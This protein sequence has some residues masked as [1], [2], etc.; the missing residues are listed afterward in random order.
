MDQSVAPP[1]LVLDAPPGLVL[2]SPQP[3]SAPP[4]LVLDPAPAPADS[5]LPPSI[6]GMVTGVLGQPQAGQKLRQMFD[7]GPMPADLHTPEGHAWLLR[8]GGGLLGGG[9]LPLK[10]PEVAA[11]DAM[12]S[13]PPATEVLPKPPFVPAIKDE[14]GVVVAGQ[15]GQIHSD[16]AE[17]MRPGVGALAHGSDAWQAGFVDANGQFL[18]RNQASASV[19]QPTSMEATDLNATGQPKPAMSPPDLA[20]NINLDKLNSPEEIKQVLRDTASANG[21]FMDARRGVIPLDQQEKLAQDLGMTPEDLLKRTLGQ[22]FN[23]E[24]AI[25]ARMLLDPSAADMMAKGRAAYGGSDLDKAIFQEALVRHAAIQ[26]QVS[27]MTAEAGRLLGSFRKVING[28]NAKAVKDLLD[29]FG[30]PGNVEDIAKAIAEMPP[31]KLG[32]FTANVLRPTWLDKVK[33]LAYAFWL[34]GPQTHMAN[35]VGNSLFPATMVPEDIAASLIGMGRAAGRKALN[36]PPSQRVYLTDVF[37]KQVG[38]LAGMGEGITNFA[39][40]MKAGESVSGQT[41]LDQMPN[42]GPTRMQPFGQSIPA[43]I[44]TSP[45]TLM[46]AED[47]FFKAMAVRSSIYEQASNRAIQEGNIPLSQKW[48]D[49]V[50]ALAN[51][52]DPAMLDAAAKHADYMTFQTELGKVGKAAMAL[53]DAVPGGFGT[54]IMPFVKTTANIFKAAIERTPAGLIMKDVRDNLRGLNGAIAR[55]RQIARTGLGTAAAVTLGQYVN[56]GLITGGGGPDKNI[57]AVATAYGQAPPYS[58]KLNGQWYSY[59]RLDPFATIM[60]LTADLVNIAKTTQ[61][62]LVDKVGAMVVTALANDIMSKTFLSGPVQWAQALTDRSGAAAKNLINSLA[63]SAIP[64]FEAQ[65]AQSQDPFLRDAQTTLDA[66]KARTQLS[67]TLPMRVTVLGDPVPRPGKLGPAILSPINKVTPNDDPVAK[68]LLRLQ[69]VPGQPQ[70]KIGGVQLTPEQ[71]SQYAQL[72]GT[73]S[74]AR[75]AKLIASPKWAD[76]PDGVKIDQIRAAFN[77]ARELAQEKIRDA[78]PEIRQQETNAMRLHFG[79]PALPMPPPSQ[80]GVSMFG[81]P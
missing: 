61:G 3:Q 49:R 32:S 24:Q 69:M 71:Y 4:G 7:P 63:G 9:E 53:R 50:T 68:E 78:Y 62:P 35:I 72:A 77:G 12:P 23:S 54:W 34:S 51:N 33:A 26:E 21:D 8:Q 2:D 25:A 6:R 73:D 13:V 36:L 42:A 14:N 64:G 59:A 16:I 5:S 58:V 19:G 1:G 22:A 47:E 10:I 17:Q 15:P 55:D 75:I 79:K 11:V 45:S 30:G 80:G 27:G 29:Q 41:K 74:K 65:L 52:P 48:Q 38:N 37:S 81:G 70:R 20:G 18:D 43:R 76:A 46:A 39:K 57:N 44:L 67:T 40:T 28:G 60:G 56:Q 31:D 66:I